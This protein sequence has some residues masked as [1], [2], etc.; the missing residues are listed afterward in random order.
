MMLNAPFA[1]QLLKPNDTGAPP[2]QA[3]D[4]VAG[5]TRGLAFADLFE[6]FS[7]APLQASS[8]MSVGPERGLKPLQKA[9]PDPVAG[10]KEEQ[11]IGEATVDFAQVAVETEPE[12]ESQAETRGDLEIAKANPQPLPN[13]EP[14]HRVADA[15]DI[16]AAPERQSGGQVVETNA[17]PRRVSLDARSDV[18]NPVMRGE[19]FVQAPRARAP[20][21]TTEGERASYHLPSDGLELSRPTHKEA[22]LGPMEARAD[23]V[24]THEPQR[25]R[26]RDP[27]SWQIAGLQAPVAAAQIGQTKA[28]ALEQRYDQPAHMLRSPGEEAVREEVA[29]KEVAGERIKPG[30]VPA[31]APQG[32]EE[33]LTRTAMEPVIGQATGESKAP[34]MPIVERLGR[35]APPEEKPVRQFETTRDLQAVPSETP[36]VDHP[37]EH[38]KPSD[39]RATISAPTPGFGTLSH[40][41]PPASGAVSTESARERD[42]LSSEGLP[43]VSHAELGRSLQQASAVAAPVLNAERA[44]VIVR[45]ALDEMV[46]TKQREIELQLHPKEL[47]K[48]RFVMSAG[49]GQMLVQVFAE[50]PETLDALRRHADILAREF[51]FEGFDTASFNFSQD[52]SDHSDIAPSS[53]EGEAGLEPSKPDLDVSRYEWRK[54][55]ARLDIRI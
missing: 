18:Q 13:A 25:A 44:I 6:R 52:R 8:Q 9:E 45:D 37:E 32:L 12:N 39:M 16:P 36:P 47:G 30:Y 53:R 55:D 46:N 10:S 20:E 40:F 33:R 23:K 4:P 50:R 22:T 41:V 7:E 43:Q 2:P 54:L 17:D 5:E 35:F 49:E 27:A 3:G 34:P 1:Q 38:P 31:Q 15:P 19:A 21:T 11:A 24:D 28:P 14:Q 48:L 42:L 29:G 26:E 51:S